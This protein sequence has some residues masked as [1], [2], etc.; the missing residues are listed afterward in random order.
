MA[1]QIKLTKNKHLLR[2]I[3][4]L[5][6]TAEVETLEE[7]ELAKNQGFEKFIFNG[8]RWDKEEDIV[9]AMKVDAL[10]VVEKYQELLRAI[11]L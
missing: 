1:F 6:G 11:F 2:A 5:G 3:A 8:M 9:E 4:E 10:I 7:L